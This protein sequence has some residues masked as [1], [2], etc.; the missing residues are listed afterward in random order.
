MS[1]E[2]HGIANTLASLAPSFLSLPPWLLQ[3]PQQSTNQDTKA[4]YGKHA[5]ALL[6][7]FILIIA[8][9]A[10]LYCGSPCAKKQ[11]GLVSHKQRR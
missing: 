5:A 9:I 10:A 3:D 6:G 2:S 4:V 11:Q 7:C 8:S 1:A